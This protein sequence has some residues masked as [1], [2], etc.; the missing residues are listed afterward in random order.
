VPN[1]ITRLKIL[2]HFMKGWISLT[3]METIMRIPRELEYFER[4]VK[5]ARKKD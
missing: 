2:L 5:L 1:S 4:L 3:P